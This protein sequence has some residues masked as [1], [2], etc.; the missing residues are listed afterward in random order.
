[1]LKGDVYKL[2]NLWKNYNLAVNAFVEAVAFDIQNKAKENSPFQTWTLR[3]SITHDIKTNFTALV[4][5]PVKYAKYVEMWH[6]QTPWRYVAAI[7]KRLKKSFV[8]WKP[9]LITA[10]QDT[11][12]ELPNIAKRI[13]TKYLK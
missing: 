13:F 1:M 3:K 7:W 8:E 10:V 11:N 2:E 5:S 6:K 4:W 12:K 9:Y